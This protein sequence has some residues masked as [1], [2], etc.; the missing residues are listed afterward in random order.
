[1]LTYQF[2]NGLTN[3]ISPTNGLLLAGLAIARIRFSQWFKVIFPF[4]LIAL[5]LAAVLALVSTY[6]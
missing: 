4:Y 1:V 5:P 2:G 3:L 6:V